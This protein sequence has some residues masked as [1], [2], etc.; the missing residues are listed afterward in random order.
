[1]LN[2]KKPDVKDKWQISQELPSSWR[3]EKIWL[4]VLL[5]G[6]Y[7][8]MWS[9]ETGLMQIKCAGLICLWAQQVVAEWPQLQVIKWPFSGNND[10]RGRWEES[11]NSSFVGCFIPCMCLGEWIPPWLWLKGQMGR[12]GETSRWEQLVCRTSFE[13]G[14]QQ[15]WPD[16]A[17]QGWR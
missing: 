13:P 8:E 6:M 9:H 11:C 10:G 1:M 7:L 5:L 12:G 17:W 3:D 4:L 14:L 15:D 16:A 2:Q